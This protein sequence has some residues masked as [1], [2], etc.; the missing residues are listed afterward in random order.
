M[1][2]KLSVKGHLDEKDLCATYSLFTKLRAGHESSLISWDLYEMVTRD[3]T[4]RK[5]KRLLIGC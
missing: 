5:S 1:T 2:S 3:S 4:R